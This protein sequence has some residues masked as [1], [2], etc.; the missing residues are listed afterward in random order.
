VEADGSSSNGVRQS[1]ASTSVNPVAS[2]ALPS[3]TGSS[4][5]RT[6]ANA[7]RSVERFTSSFSSVLSSV[8][9]L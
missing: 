1:P 6:A 7:V 4:G 3:E 9:V 8:A 5:P 2:S